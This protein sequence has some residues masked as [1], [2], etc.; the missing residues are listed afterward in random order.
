VKVF[1]EDIPM[2]PHQFLFALRA[3]Y[4]IALIVLAGTMAA[5]LAVGLS[6]P[7]RYTATTSMVVDVR[8]RDP[9]A[10]MFMPSGTGT[11]VEII[12]S[13][14]VAQRVVK[15]LKLDESQTMRQQWQEVASGKSQFE[16]W[17]IAKLEKNLVVKPQGDIINITYSAADPGLAAAG[18]NAF[19]QAYIEAVVEM[20]VEPAKQYAKWFGEQAKVLRENVEQAQLR[21]SRY[22][23]SKGIVE[24]QEQLDYETGKLRELSSQLTVVQAQTNDA[25]SRHKSGADTLPEIMANPVITGLKSDIARREA[26][27]EETALNLGMNHPQYQR[28]E[29]ELA[30]LK[31]KLQAETQN[32]T[33]SYSTASTVGQSNEAGLK[34]A[35]E[36]QKKKLLA[37]K[38]Q[39]NEL[40]V[41]QRDVDAATSAYDAVAN[42]FNQ[43]SLESQ[44]TT[45]TN[46]SVLN[47]AVEPIAPSTPKPLR[48]MLLISI[49]LG[50]V[51]S[52][53]VT[54]L[55]ETFDRRIR[56]ADDLAEMLQ[57]PV[58]G[59]IQGVRERKNL[60]LLGIA[61]L[62][63]R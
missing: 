60:P 27:L 49:A 32:I 43:T 50:A 39:R 26:T 20:K 15:L 21:L 12:K 57:L 61:R 41:L 14:R 2:T 29:S 11:Q 46:V 4:R 52:I 31:K 63:L 36:A 5:G 3:R 56:S 33:R 37:L 47:P 45:Q 35:I 22:Q 23:Q 17:L 16:P 62:R 58:L 40:D 51:A 25:R 38:N 48:I 28:L 55:L 18:A 13:D 34:A 59:V 19:A 42:R 10:A 44:S 24:R 7:K 53:G 9:V 6:L 1:S 8:N 30:S 54:F